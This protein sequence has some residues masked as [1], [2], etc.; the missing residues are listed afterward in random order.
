MAV[1]Q[2]VW[3]EYWGKHGGTEDY[4]EGDLGDTWRY[5]GHYGGSNWRCKAVLVTLG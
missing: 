1:L 5:W 3:W 4:M 2:T